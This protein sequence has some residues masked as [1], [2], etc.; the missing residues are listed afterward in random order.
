MHR[1][2][3]IGL[4]LILSL[5]VVVPA[6]AQ[7]GENAAW[8]AIEDERDARRRA[9]RLVSF[10]NAYERSSRRPEADIMLVNYWISN[11]DNARIMQHAEAFR[12]NLPSADNAS[13]AFV[14]TQAMVAA[15]TLNN[16]AK[17]VEFSGYALQA[18][19]ENLT[20]LGFLA[21]L[22]LPNPAE[23]L[24]HAQKALTLPR[25]ATMGEAQYNSLQASL[26][27][28]VG[29]ALFLEQKFKEADEKLSI[30]LKANPKDHVNQFR[31]G[32]S[33]I[34]LAGDAAK[35][36]SAANDDLIKAMTATPVQTEAVDAAKAKVEA[37]SQN[38]LKHRDMAIEALAK[39]VAIGGQFGSQAKQLLDS[40][41]QSK[42]K[43][44]DGLDA[45]LGQKKAELGLP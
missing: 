16:V 5:I 9:E 42:N 45:F 4:C 13:K 25:P 24:K 12:Q 1:I 3:S 14:Y 37:E 31:L 22:N 36:A 39:A 33:N 2:I 35:A 26:N 19:P 38:A 27:G 44:L 30:A 17:T 6:F 40:L 10:I 23:A 15:A 43:S 34:S 18:E 32:F 7:G 21:R 20:V 41:Y 28:V 8:Q 11:K 29:N